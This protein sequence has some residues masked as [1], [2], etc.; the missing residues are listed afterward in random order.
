METEQHQGLFRRRVVADPDA[1]ADLQNHVACI[2][3]LGYV[4]YDRLE[5]RLLRDVSCP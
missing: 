1:T 5:G 2:S 4:V 3:Y